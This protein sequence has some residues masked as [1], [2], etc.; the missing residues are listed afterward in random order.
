MVNS[1]SITHASQTNE[2][3]K[4]AAAPKPQPQQKSSPQPSDTVTLK[5]TVGAKGAST[6]KDD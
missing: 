3:V 2:A 6:D 4:T 5:S 1:I